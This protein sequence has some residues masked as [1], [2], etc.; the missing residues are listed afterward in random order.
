MV[1]Y[2]ANLQSIPIEVSEA[3]IVDGA[4]TW[5][6]VMRIKVPLL[7]HSFNI[8]SIL[9]AIGIFKIYE[10]ILFMT[11]GGPAN[12]TSVLTYYMVRRLNHGFQYAYASALSVIL[13]IIIISLTIIINQLVF[14]KRFEVEY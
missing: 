2:L 11:N 13:T 12:S 8:I 4:N 6:I 7:R 3:A 9:T 1:I 5:N 10:L 14:H